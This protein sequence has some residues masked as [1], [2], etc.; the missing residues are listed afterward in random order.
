MNDEITV[1]TG[2]SRY[3]ND[4]DTDSVHLVVT[5][6]PYPMIKMWDD[7]FAKNGCFTF[8]EMHDYLT[9][10]WAECYRVLID[11]GMMCINI[12]DAVRTQNG[13]FR[14]FSNHS[15]TLEIMNDLGFVTL[16]YILWKKPTNKPNAF[17]GSGFLPPNAYVTIDCEYILIFRKGDK[18]NFEPKNNIRNESKYTKN[19]RDVWFSQIW[20]V[21][22]TQQNDVETKRRLAAYP[23]EIP[24]RLIRMFSVIGD[25]VLDPFLG[26]GTTISAAIKTRRNFIGYEIDATIVDIVKRKYYD[27]KI[28]YKIQDIKK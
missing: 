16:P 28:E 12:G 1:I 13:I 22:G 20:N 8:D 27:T 19:E 17:L 7:I 6:P 15:R 9:G 21:V 11:G 2:D 24:Y 18:R 26:S 23:E 10:T 4:I 5:S 25:N 3:M 14:L